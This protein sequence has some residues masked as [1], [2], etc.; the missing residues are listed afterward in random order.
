MVWQ[1]ECPGIVMLTKTFDYIRVMCVQYWPTSHR[2]EQYGDLCVS[3]TREVYYSSYIQRTIRLVKHGQER[4]VVH[5]QFTEWPCYSNP[6]SGALLNF[7]RMVAAALDSSTS[8][9]PPV[10]HCHDGGGRSGVFLLL[11]AN[12]RLIQASQQVNI[13]SYLTKMRRP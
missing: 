11:D 9:G 10:I 1:E 4:E 12:I 5:F 3:V 13:Y 2:E 7:R 6:F 8:T